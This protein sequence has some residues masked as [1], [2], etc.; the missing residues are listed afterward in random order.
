MKEKRAVKRRLKKL[1][2][3]LKAA[4]NIITEKKKRKEKE[5]ITNR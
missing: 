3:S 1:E 4:S 2:S 5:N